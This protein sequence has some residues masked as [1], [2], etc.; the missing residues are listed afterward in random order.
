MA[1]AADLDISAEEANELL[2]E[3]ERDAA[4]RLGSPTPTRRKEFPEHELQVLID[5]A[6]A[7]PVE[8]EASSADMPS[9]PYPHPDSLMLAIVVENSWKSIPDSLRTPEVKLAIL[10][11]AVHAWMEGHIDGETLCR[12]DCALPGDPLH[13]AHNA[14]LRRSGGGRWLTTEADA[15]R[16]PNIP[17]LGARPIRPRA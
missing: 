12:G 9:P 8:D 1:E 16:T 17:H 13:E 10:H 3:I 7:V 4:L 5:A 14:R 15:G 11:A 2:K 6:A